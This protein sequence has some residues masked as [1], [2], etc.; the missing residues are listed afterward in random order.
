MR[1]IFDILHWKF[2]F[3]MNGAINKGK[4][5]SCLKCTFWI[6]LYHI[7]F[8]DGTKKK[9]HPQIWHKRVF[10]LNAKCIAESF[11]GFWGDKKKSSKITLWTAKIVRFYFVS[12]ESWAVLNHVHVENCRELHKWNEINSAVSAESGKKSDEFVLKWS[13]ECEFDVCNIK[14]RLWSCE[15]RTFCVCSNIKF[16][17]HD[18]TEKRESCFL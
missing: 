15:P 17:S 5:L 13:C 6:C 9:I 1:G 10:H 3:K 11:C 8:R 12:F 7:S 16:H 2:G 18:D 4:L 14:P